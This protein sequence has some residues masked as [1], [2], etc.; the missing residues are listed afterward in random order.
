MPI[1]KRPFPWILLL[2][3]V[4]AGARI[5]NNLPWCDE[6]W[7]FDPVYNWITKGHT[8]TTIE[9]ATGLPWKGIERHMYW[10]APMHL[11]V[12]SLWL[13]IF[14]LNIY[15][16]RACSLFAGLVAL[17]CWRYLLK[18]IQLPSV[19]LN[20]S[21]VLIATDYAFVRTGSDGRIDMIASAFGLCAVVSYL[22]LRERN[23]TLAVLV[24]QTFAVC[25]GLTHPMGGLLYLAYIAFFFFM[26][27]DWQRLRWIHLPIA[28]APY[29][30][31]AACWGAYIMQE[32]ETF[33]KLF[34]GVSAAG[35][36]TGIL[37]PLPSLQ[38]EIYVRYLIP[39]GWTGESMALKIKTLIPLVYFAG[40]IAA[41]G[42][43]AVR[44]LPHM[45]ALLALW[46][47]AFLGMYI[48]DNQRN[49]TYLC[50][51][52]PLY[53]AILAT[54]LYWMYQSRNVLLRPLSAL[55]LTGF[56]LLQIGGSAYIIYTS[57][58]QNDFMAAVRFAEQHAKPGSDH[59]I[60][61]PEMGFG[62]GFDNV[63]D[64]ASLGYFNHKRPVVIIMDARLRHWMDSFSVS[65]PDAYRFARDRLNN[66]FQLAYAHGT[67]EVYVPNSAEKQASSF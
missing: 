65:H 53:A 32:P 28:A 45:R 55:V 8:G 9:E 61:S 27:R 37:R 58:F 44:R 51:I 18:Y 50:H 66:E 54:V 67:H 15:A 13:R 30:V 38:N 31:G 52:F 2:F 25:G 60:G 46:A 39:N 33:K 6:G 34:L 35:R 22:H 3:V 62:L 19:I 20:L 7:F 47:I 24:S 29:L 57:P 16:F 40:I 17:F 41:I 5:F 56:L 1:Y 21:L 23:Y 36:L 4:L 43:P 48:L 59:I 64:D 10:Q 49:G 11:L 63:L 14:G 42:I 12:H 26:R